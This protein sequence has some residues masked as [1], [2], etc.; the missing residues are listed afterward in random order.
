[1]SNTQKCG[2]LQKMS[3]HVYN[4]S[5]CFSVNYKEHHD[6]YTKSFGYLYLACRFKVCHLFEFKHGFGHGMFSQHE[7]S[8][9]I[10]LSFSFM[11]GMQSQYVA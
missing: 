1:M 7:G 9:D 2:L 4:L 8:F 11:H 3:H 6:P 5:E 10:L